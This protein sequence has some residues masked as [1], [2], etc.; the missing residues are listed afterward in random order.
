M[1]ENFVS[2]REL[3][4]EHQPTSPSKE[5]HS[6]TPMSPVKSDRPKIGHTIYVF[7]YSVT[8]EVLKKAFQPYGNIVNISMEIEK[9]YVNL[10]FLKHF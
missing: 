9:K 6:P 4:Q 5:Q 10:V 8:E 1:Y 7:G 2:S 3:E